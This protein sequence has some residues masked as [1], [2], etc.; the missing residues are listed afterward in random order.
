[1]KQPDA[2]V[3]ILLQEQGY[4]TGQFTRIEASK[5][6]IVYNSD[7]ELDQYILRE[8]YLEQ[9]TS[10]Q[11]YLG[12]GL[13]NRYFIKTNSELKTHGISL[14]STIGRQRCY[15]TDRGISCRESTGYYELVVS[16]GHFR[17][18]ECNYNSQS[19]IPD[20]T[21]VAAIQFE[22]FVGNRFV[23]L[24][25][26]RFLHSYIQIEPLPKSETLQ[27]LIY[28]FRIVPTDPI[29]GI[30]RRVWKNYSHRQIWR[31]LGRD[32]SVS[33]VIRKQVIEEKIKDIIYVSV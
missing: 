25:R 23:V 26:R 1:M 24:I 7:E 29:L 16:E 18:R 33:V 3:G 12:L 4:D 17:F 22:E 31:L 5:L 9:S 6:G 30:T 11:S 19:Q 28:S 2:V 21:I 14:V 15:L 8:M 20:D 32:K 10:D 27:S 13:N